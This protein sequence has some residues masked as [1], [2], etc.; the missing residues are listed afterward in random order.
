MC[1]WNTCV[2]VKLYYPREFSKTTEVWVDK[3][4]ANVIQ[5]LN[6]EKIHTESCCCGHNKADPSLVIADGYND[7]EIKK[8]IKMIKQWDNRNWNIKQWRIK[9]V[10]TTKLGIIEEKHNV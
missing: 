8:I 3:C 4:I 6:N 7:K 10:A 2:K 5:K 1:K 9:T